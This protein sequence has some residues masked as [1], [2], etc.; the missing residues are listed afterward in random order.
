MTSIFL[1][2]VLSLFCFAQGLSIAA[3]NSAHPKVFAD[4]LLPAEKWVVEYILPTKENQDFS[5]SA[6]YPAECS[7]CPIQ[8]A[9]LDF[10]NKERPFIGKRIYHLQAT[11]GQQIEV[12][13]NLSSDGA[14]R[15]I[16][17][18]PPHNKGKD[19]EVFFVKSKGGYLIRIDVSWQG[20]ERTN[21][22]ME[23]QKHPFTEWK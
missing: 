9:L 11:N 21:F 8:L 15:N 20:E 19:N 16:S 23:P 7:S 6:D 14:I 12:K 1:S 13:V 22:H 2:S 3:S 5:F 18:D 4:R 10:P 17:V